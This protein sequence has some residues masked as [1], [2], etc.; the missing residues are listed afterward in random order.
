MPRGGL[1]LLA[2]VVLYVIQRGT[3]EFAHMG[4]TDSAT[5]LIFT[6]FCLNAAVFPLHAWLP[7][8]YPRAT[9]SG[10]VFMSALT[11]KSAVYILARTFPGNDILLWAGAFMTCFPI[12]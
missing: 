8:A 7:D 6:G 11:T 5:L 10:A 9:V 12:F 1:C 2:G 4:L 3:A